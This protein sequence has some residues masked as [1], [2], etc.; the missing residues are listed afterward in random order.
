M[1]RPPSWLN[2]HPYYRK[3]L[4]AAGISIL[5]PDAVSDE[6][7][8]QTR[9]TFLAMLSD[10]PDLLKTMVEHGFRILIYPDRFE[11]GGRIVDLPEFSNLNMSSRVR[12]RRRP[13]PPTA[14]SLAH[15]KSPAIA[16]T[17]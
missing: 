15:P 4:D 11:K 17:S 3:Y 7:L 6:E 12:R 1:Q 2:P 16:I 8:Y 5:A 9:T 10:R 13:E 14:G